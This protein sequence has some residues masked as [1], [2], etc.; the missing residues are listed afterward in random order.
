MNRVRCSG[1]YSP[2]R[3]VLFSG[4]AKLIDVWLRGGAS[5]SVLSSCSPVAV[6]SARRRSLRWRLQCSPLAVLLCSPHIE[7]PKQF[8]SP[9]PNG[10]RVSERQG[11]PSH[12]RQARI[13]ENREQKAP[14]QNRARR[15]TT[16]R[17]VTGEENNRVRRI[18]I[19]PVNP[20]PRG[21]GEKRT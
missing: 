3:V 2:R 8:L 20:N 16:Q 4:H 6:L 18:D 1:L 7:S 15:T 5:C 11:K 17:R 9:R 19:R 21:G 10:S 12:P 13:R 14:R